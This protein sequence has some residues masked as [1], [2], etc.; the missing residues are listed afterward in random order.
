LIEPAYTEINTFNS[1]ALT[2]PAEKG[3]MLI[4]PSYLAHGVE[5]GTSKDD[6]DRIVVAFNIMIRGTIDRRTAR[7]ELK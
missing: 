2:V 5:Y 3:L 4:W 7:L 1:A 6:E